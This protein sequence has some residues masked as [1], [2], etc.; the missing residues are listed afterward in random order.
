MMSAGVGGV[1]AR[2]IRETLELL[3][4]TSEAVRYMGNLLLEG[5]S[6]RTIATALEV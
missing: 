1:L 3:Q 6:Q 4:V 2:P 5:Q